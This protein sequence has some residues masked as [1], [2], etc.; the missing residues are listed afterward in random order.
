M[1][2]PLLRHTALLVLL[3]VPAAV[4]AQE[5]SAR[6]EERLAALAR[7]TDW[8]TPKTDFSMG[9]RM[10]SSGVKVHFGKLGT[11]PYNSIPAPGSDGL[12]ARTYN[13]GSVSVDR[14][15]SNEQDAN[16]NQTSQ[17]GGR[18]QIGTTDASG[19]LTTTNDLLAYTPGL[20]RIWS[21][22][23]P[24][25]AL[26]RPGYIA[27][28]SYSATSD[29]AMADKKQ[30]A[31]LGVELQLSHTLYQVTK[32][33]SV[34]LSAGLAINGINNKTTGDVSATLN[35]YTDYYSLHGQAAPTTSLTAVYS[36]PTFSDLTSNGVVFSNGFET[37]VPISAQPD[38][39]TLTAVTGGTTVHGL[40]EV[41]GAY[42]ML[43]F[44][45]SLRAQ[46]TSR[47]TLTASL[48][49][50]GAYSGTT[51]SA[52]ESFLIPVVGT[53]ITESTVT[54]SANKLLSGYYAD[55]NLEFAANER[56]GLYGGVSLQKLGAYDQTLEG[57]TAH[58]D[59]GTSSGV[60]GGVNI[61]F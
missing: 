9:F 51:Y 34:G 20:T 48:G 13:N 21:Y 47:L 12:V 29:G 33:I 30:G 4:F 37:T 35:T 41:K 11:V 28:S 40:W 44:G 8:Y 58:I 7:S 31:S 18:Y 26:T 6:E 54:S 55:L 19:T 3:A 39:N 38:A 15:R 50:A 2:F 45:P 60:R 24:D 52:T 59:I 22:S 10:L 1:S 16:G 53:S 27:L 42:M 23:T 36:S 5:E 46:V 43:R 56:T 25:Q 57:R 49:L 32:R 14:A 61:R 17:P